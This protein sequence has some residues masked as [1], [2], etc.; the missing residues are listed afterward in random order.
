[1]LKKKKKTF[2][3]EQRN[4]KHWWLA[5]SSVFRRVLPNVNI[6][7][8]LGF[9]VHLIGRV[10]KTCRASPG[11]AAVPAEQSVL[12]TG[13]REVIVIFWRR[14][15]KD[16]PSGYFSHTSRVRRRLAGGGRQGDTDEG[17]RLRFN[18]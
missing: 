2:R 1:M 11:A 5:G 3:D 18:S 9:A 16:G 14:E 12:T 4:E 15:E 6:I 10:N 7:C 13:A 8:V 17:A